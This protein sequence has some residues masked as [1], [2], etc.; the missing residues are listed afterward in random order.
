[1]YVYVYLHIENMGGNC[2]NTNIV[3]ELWDYCVLL[4]CSLY[5]AMLFDI[6]FT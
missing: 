3:S 5:V 1:M 4:P 2:W 6:F